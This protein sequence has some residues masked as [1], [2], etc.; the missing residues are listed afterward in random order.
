MV[1]H[2]FHDYFDFGVGLI[3]FD[4]LCVVPATSEHNIQTSNNDKF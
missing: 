1:C 3:R 2:I 4:E